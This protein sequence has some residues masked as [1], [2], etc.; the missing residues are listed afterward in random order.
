MLKFI[1]AVALMF[2]SIVFMTYL[3]YALYFRNMRKLGLNPWNM[4]WRALN[5]K[6]PV[7]WD[8]VKVPD[9]KQ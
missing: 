8:K 4:A 1:F 2:S 5:F 9:A 6:G 7:D 3:H